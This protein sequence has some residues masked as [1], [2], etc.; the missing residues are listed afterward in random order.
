MNSFFDGYIH[1]NTT[2]KEFVEQ[3]DNALRKKVQKEDEANAQSLNVRIQQESTRLRDIKAE[4]D[5]DNEECISNMPTVEDAEIDMETVQDKSIILGDPSKGPQR[6]RPPTKRKQSMTKQI[7]RK[8]MKSNKRVQCS[9]ANAKSIPD[10]EDHT[11]STGLSRK[12]VESLLYV[13]E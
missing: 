1:S 6:G 12:R 2:L 10:V 4:N 5:L 7:I 9:S 8:N 13:L 11:H 3:Y